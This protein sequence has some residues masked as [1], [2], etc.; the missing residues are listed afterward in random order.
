M[1]VVGLEMPSQTMRAVVSL[2]MVVWTVWYT[3]TLDN[4]APNM[5]LYPNTS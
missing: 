4:P 1:P 2:A 3:S 5:D